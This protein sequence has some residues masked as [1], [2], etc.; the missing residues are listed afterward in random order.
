MRSTTRRTTRL[1]ALGTLTVAGAAFLG[2]GP[3]AAADDAS[4]QANLSQLNDS[5][6][7]GT[8]MVTV[9]GNRVHVTLTTQGLLAGAPHAQHI[10][11]GGKNVCPTNGEKGSGANGALQVMD[12]AD[13]YG[14]I[15]VSLTKTGD[16]SPKSGL[17]VD[18]FPTASG[19]YERTITVSDATAAQLRQGNGQVVVHGVDL[20][21]S[22][23]YDGTVKSEL[24]PSLPEE[25][26]DPAACGAL[27]LSQMSGMPS[28][29]VSTGGGS[30]AG[31]EDGSL[32]GAGGI[33]LAVGFGLGAVALRRRQTS[34]VKAGA[35]A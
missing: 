13:S 24:D 5:G 18:R 23:K 11:I 19:T 3:A 26:T 1:T 12:A 32:I 10:H 8:A 4:L 31:I 25:A 21:K 34:M 28:G 17:A 29:G 22:G 35:K 16:T 14:A 6:A 20:N 2:A 30:T 15:A 33:L 27:S 7:S 9:S